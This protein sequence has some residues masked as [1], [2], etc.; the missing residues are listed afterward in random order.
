MQLLSS[1]AILPL[2]SNK[3]SN[4]L[5]FAYLLIYVNWYKRCNTLD[6]VILSG[7]KSLFLY[8]MENE[9][10]NPS[11]L[12]EEQMVEIYASVCCIRGSHSLTDLNSTV[13]MTKFS[14][15]FF[16]LKPKGLL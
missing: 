4:P 2:S 8:H 14:Y 1:V 11:S 15:L 7:W 10:L 6:A 5:L 13:E 9:M 16:S 3:Q 12:Q